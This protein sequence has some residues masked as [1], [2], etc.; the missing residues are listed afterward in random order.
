MWFELVDQNS[1]DT[2]PVNATTKWKLTTFDND[3]ANGWE[4]HKALCLAQLK[5]VEDAL[6]ET[7]KEAAALQKQH[8]QLVFD[9]GP[10]VG[11]T[12]K[13]VDLAGADNEGRDSVGAVNR[14]EQLELADVNKSM[15]AL[16]DCLR[17]IAGVPG[18]PK[19]P[20]FR[21]SNLTR[22]L[23]DSLAPTDGM[24]SRKNPTSHTVLLTC[25]SPA[26]AMEKKTVASLRT[27]QIFV[28]DTSKRAVGTPKAK[29]RKKK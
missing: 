24:T 19:K 10:A 26:D 8:D 18:A 21:N 9:M 16:K 22:L 2:E 1:A 11:G 4:R 7:I 27:G 28:K 15:L 29:N 5:Q 3:E 12:L 17:A 25:V 13:F 23:Q 20:P 14:E 6:A